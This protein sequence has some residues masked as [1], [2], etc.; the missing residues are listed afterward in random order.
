[1]SSVAGSNPFA[2]RHIRPGA[3]GYLFQEGVSAAEL[4]ERLKAA[5]WWGQIV[6]PHGSGKSTLLVTLVQELESAGRRVRL[7]SL[8]QGEHRLPRLEGN[9]ETATQVVVDGYEQ[10]SWWSKRKL[11]ARCRRAGSGLLVT[12]H[13]DMGLP[14][15]FETASSLEV[16]KEVVARLVEAADGRVTEDDVSEAFA[17]SGGNVRE[18]LFALYDIYQGRASTPEST[19]Y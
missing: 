6:G 12:A 9:L 18:T 3:I 15:I 10:L 16:T 19:K 14:T 8:H 13:A 11:K 5:G 7:V 2:S 4:V 1:M 17:A